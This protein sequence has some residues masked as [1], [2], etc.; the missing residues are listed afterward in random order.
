MDM[1]KNT[2]VLN[3]TLGANEEQQVVFTHVA[4]DAAIDDIM[5]M[6]PETWRELPPDIGVQPGSGVVPAKPSFQ[7]IAADIFSVGGKDYRVG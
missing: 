2:F 3:G 6:L 7:S 4:V 5:A 1:A